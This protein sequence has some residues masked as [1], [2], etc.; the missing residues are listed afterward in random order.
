M[1]S[2]NNHVVMVGM[3]RAG[4]SFMYH[5]LQK[6][7]G[8]FL[9][10]RKEIGYFAHH[11]NQGQSWYKEFYTDADQGLVSGGGGCVVDHIPSLHE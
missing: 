3:S 7:P 9:P 6:H 1:F 2:N 11:H 4:T 5:N 10:S 8:L